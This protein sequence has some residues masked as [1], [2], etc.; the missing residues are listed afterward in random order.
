M[1]RGGWERRWRRRHLTSRAFHGGLISPGGGPIVWLAGVATIQ[2]SPRTLS[3]VKCKVCDR[4]ATS[5][6]LGQ[7]L[8]R[9]ATGCTPRQSLLR[10]I[11]L[12]VCAAS[13]CGWVRPGSGVVV[14]VRGT[15]LLLLLLVV[16]L[17]RVSDAPHGTARA[18][19]KNGRVPLAVPFTRGAVFGGGRGGSH[20][21]HRHAVPL[22]GLHLGA[23]GSA[24]GGVCWSR[25]ADTTALTIH[26]MFIVVCVRRR[27]WH[28]LSAPSGR[29][30]RCQ[31]I[32]I[33]GTGSVRLDVM[34]AIGLGVRRKTNGTPWLVPLTG[35]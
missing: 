9:A 27:R 31:A 18:L 3:S 28:H 35:L 12:C 7:T 17:R 8:L 4:V 16:L 25:A 22:G 20:I 6:A 11:L 26:G 14:M 30:R 15:L 33:S 19:L 21:K 29:T 23:P 34:F 2:W 5:L 32:G 10:I 13:L 24:A 1:R